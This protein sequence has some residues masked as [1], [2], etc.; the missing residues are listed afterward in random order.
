MPTLERRELAA[1]PLPEYGPQQLGKMSYETIETVLRGIHKNPFAKRPRFGHASFNAPIPDGNTSLRERE[2]VLM[3]SA[4]FSQGSDN[5]AIRIH[6][7]RETGEADAQF[8]TRHRMEF[9]RYKTVISETS[10][11]PCHQLVAE[12]EVTTSVIEGVNGINTFTDGGV[13]VTID[14]TTVIEEYERALTAFETYFGEAFGE[15]KASAL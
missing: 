8:N 2:L 7:E 15:A 1:A 6:T 3:E 12:A 11:L 13:I 5:F 9:S 10:G 4:R 14:G